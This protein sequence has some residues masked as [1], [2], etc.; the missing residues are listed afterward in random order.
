M[1][2]IRESIKNNQFE[3]FVKDFMEE[4]FKGREYPDWIVD[5]LKAV[6]IDL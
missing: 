1:K 5:S 6:N 4:H 3:K 2:D